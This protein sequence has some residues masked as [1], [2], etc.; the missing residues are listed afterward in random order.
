METAVKKLYE[1]MFLVDTAQAVADW[2]GLIKAIRTI[3]EKSGADIISIR[4]WDDRSLAYEVDHKNRGT[5]IL[6]Y[7]RVA[8]EV[9]TTIERDVRLSER[10]MRMLILAA[11]HMSQEDIEKDTPA[12]IAEKHPQIAAEPEAAVAEKVEPQEEF[13][14]PEE[15]QE[16]LEK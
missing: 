10:V 15:L 12:M 13:E 8:G 5:Y 2:D 6:C 7:F 3:L 16:E 1:A 4:K 14:I 11:E 9:V